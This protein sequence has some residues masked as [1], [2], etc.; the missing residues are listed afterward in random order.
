MIPLIAGA[1]TLTK[2]GLALS[3]FTAVMQ[4]KQGMDTKAMYKGRARMAELEGR[5]NALQEKQRGIEVLKNTNRALASVG[6]PAV[7][8]P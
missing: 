8:N 7:P 4:I 2:V 3:A 5:Q 1:S 6:D